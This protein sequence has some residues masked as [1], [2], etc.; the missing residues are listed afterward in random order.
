MINNKFLNFT[1]NS[2]N[3]ES[4]S[5]IYLVKNISNNSREVWTVKDKIAVKIL[6]T[7]DYYEV[8]QIDSMF[9][10]LKNTLNSKIED[11][12]EKLEGYYNNTE[13]LSIRKIY[14]T[15]TE[16]VEDKSPLDDNTKLPLSYGNLVAVIEDPE[17]SKNGIYIYKIT[18]WVYL[19]KLGD[20]SDMVTK[21]TKQ[22]ITAVKEFTQ[23][24]IISDAVEKNNPTTLKQLQEIGY[25]VESEE[26]LIALIDRN[27]TI[28]WGIKKDGTVYYPKG[29]P[30]EVRPIL[31]SLVSTIEKHSESILNKVDKI[32]GSGLIE[33]EVAESFYFVQNEEYLYAIVDKEDFVLFGIRKDGNLYLGNKYFLEVILDIEDRLELT[34]DLDGNIIS[35]RDSEGVLHE[36]TG[37]N[38]SNITS[39]TIDSK[40]INVQNKIEFSDSALNELTKDFRE[41]GFKSGNGD[42]SLEKYLELPIPQVAAVVNF[43]SPKGMPTTKTDDIEAE[44]EYIDKL[45]NY[46]K[47]PIVWNCQG[48][49]SMAYAKKN[50]KFDLLDDSEIKFGNWVAQDSFHLKAY[51]IDIFRG[52]NNVCYNLCEA[53]YQTRPL[54]ERR[55]W[56]YLL[57]KETDGYSAKGILKED[58]KTGALAHPDGFP[59]IVNY[60]GE[61]YGV[62]TWNLKKHRDNYMLDKK[63]PTHIMLDGN[64]APESMWQGNIKWNYFEIKN[65]KSLIDINGNK[66]DGDNPIEISDTDP[67]TKKVKEALIR[68]STAIP[69]IEKNQTK[70]EVAKYFNI[71]FLI[72]YFIEAQVVFNFDGVSKNWIW[73]TWDGIIWTPTF[74][75]QDSVFGMNAGGTYVYDDSFDRTIG[76]SRL[77]P[78][79]WI[80]KL[81]QDETIVRYKELRDKDVISVQKIV[82]MF[83][84]WVDRVGYDNYKREIKKWDTIPSY[85]DSLINE[86]WKLVTRLNKEAP[87]YDSN[88]TYSKDD[89]CNYTVESS[90][91][92]FKAQKET[93]GILPCRGSYNG[94]KFGFYNSISRIEHWLEKRIEYCDKIFK[95]NK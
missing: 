47:K 64:L 32:D 21:S 26:W 35:Y 54:K 63:D 65:P 8:I 22:I 89:I 87:M 83:E 93:K 40:V 73:C 44:I 45:G 94:S 46:F 49:S 75:D 41:A 25:W 1:L 16:M 31:E 72:D 9:D 48:D 34:I 66:Y 79:G 29:I 43:I 38:S 3:S 90:L 77:I 88:T 60:N 67:H 14:K 59:I 70:E 69:N 51:Y 57:D 95:Y 42:W 10:S 91:F 11:L 80:D 27:H 50:F 4:P 28:L 52:Q 74:Y 39:D 55:P 37:I 81:F 78:T 61:F 53:M 19:Q 17:E 85:R 84:E 62:Y 33:T 68:L 23:P 30:E 71:P 76:I 36:K 5:G 12:E 58:Y 18:E 82:S 20:I 6:A 13:P 86:P 7:S 56:S 2:P 92:T 24:L 15:Y